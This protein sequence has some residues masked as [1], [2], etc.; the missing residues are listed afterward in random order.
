MT[1]QRRH[2]LIALLACASPWLPLAHA[3]AYEDFFDSIKRDDAAGMAALLRRGFDPNTVDAKGQTGLI[4]ALQEGSIKV[5]E[6]LIASPKT[7]VEARNP[8]DESPL[9][10]A[11]LKGHLQAVRSLLDRD[12]DVNKSGWAPLH[13]AAT[14]TGPQQLEIIALLLERHAYIDAASPNGSTPLMM[15]AQYGPIDAVQLLLKEGADSTLKNQLGLMASDFARRVGRDKLAE[16][17]MADVRRRQPRRGQ[18]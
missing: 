4:L 14:G 6:V 5:A 10:M 18:W 1:L 8:Q 16:E 11:A 13:Y 9:M 7:R 17:L 2:C 12:A 3:G 15:A